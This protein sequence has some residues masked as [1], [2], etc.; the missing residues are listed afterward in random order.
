MAANCDAGLNWLSM[1]QEPAP[2]YTPPTAAEWTA[3]LRQARASISS[4][5]NRFGFPDR[6]AASGVRGAITIYAWNELAEG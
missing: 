5:G 6:S 3:A 1:A 4:V 2:S